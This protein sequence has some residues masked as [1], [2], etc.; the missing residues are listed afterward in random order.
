MSQ[1]N[2][3]FPLEHTQQYKV[4]LEPL[5]NEP[6]V[7][8]HEGVQH[9]SQGNRT[10]LV[11]GCSCTKYNKYEPKFDSTED[12]EEKA[13]KYFEEQK[14]M[15]ENVRWVFENLIFFRNYNNNELGW[16]W[17]KYVLGFDPFDQFMTSDIYKKICKY[18]T[19][20]IIE[21]EARRLREECRLTH[22]TD[23][24]VLDEAKKNPPN[25]ITTPTCNLKTHENCSHECKYCPYDPRLVDN[26]IIK[27]YGI[28]SFFKENRL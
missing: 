7:C 14:T 17:G 18:G 3:F 25:I 16:A 26:K 19:H 20:A 23:Q 12:F 2:P 13:M 10:C 8:G 27:E 4:S 22:P 24:F 5:K 15:L 6:C 9:L 1:T 21:R 28:Y 11:A